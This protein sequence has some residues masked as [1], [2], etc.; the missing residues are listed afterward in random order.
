MTM[1]KK[2]VAAMQAEL[3][4]R[5]VEYIWAARRA[6]DSPQ[7]LGF[8]RRLLAQAKGGE[9]GRSAGQLRADLRTLR[10]AGHRGDRE[11]MAEALRNIVLKGMRAHDLS[12][13]SQGDR[14]AFVRTVLDIERWRAWEAKARAVE[15]VAVEDATRRIE[16]GTSHDKGRHGTSVL[17]LL[18]GGG[19]PAHLLPKGVPVEKQRQRKTLAEEVEGQRKTEVTIMAAAEEP[20]GWWERRAKEAKK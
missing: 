12:A 4:E 11:R 17:Q 7:R 14:V 15:R 2:R 8:L 5:G 19:T 9:M 1:N 3:R 13:M 16:L 20:A 10:E 18:L 6:G